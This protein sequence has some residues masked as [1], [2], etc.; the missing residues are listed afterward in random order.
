MM[1]LIRAYKAKPWPKLEIPSLNRT[2]YMYLT[3]YVIAMISAGLSFWFTMRLSAEY[4][5][6]LGLGIPLLFLLKNRY[7][8]IIGLLTF[9]VVMAFL[10]VGNS[11]YVIVTIL[12]FVGAIIAF[13]SPSFVYVMLVFWMWFEMSPYSGYLGVKNEFLIGLMLFVGWFFRAVFD[14]DRVKQKLVFHEK[15]PIIILL[16]WIVMGFGLWC[17]EPQPSGFY[18]L[19]FILIGVLFF[20]LSPLIINNDKLHTK[21]AWAWIIA[22]MFATYTA[23]FQSGGPEIDTGEMDLSGSWGGYTGAMGIQHS[24]SAS[25]LSMSLFVLVAAFYWMKGGLKKSLLLITGV[26][27]IAAIYVQESKGITFATA[28]GLGLFWLISGVRNSKHHKGIIAVFRILIM[29]MALTL[30]LIAVN[31]YG[32]QFSNYSNQISDPMGGTMAGRIYLWGVAYEMIINEGHMIR[33]IG[34]GAFWALAKDYGITWAHP[35]IPHANASESMDFQQLGVNPHNLYIDIILN[36]GLVGFALFLWLII[37]NLKRLWACYR[38]TTN[39]KYSYLSL[40]LFCALIAFYFSAIFDFTLFII[41][42]YWLYLGLAVAT[43]NLSKIM[44]TGNVTETPKAT[45]PVR[46]PLH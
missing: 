26:L 40:G 14:Q 1:E 37:G 34:V 10:F 44:V 9:E 13:E 32:A 28:L 6:S 7:L 16:V 8:T 36:Y 20:I 43:V 29:V 39:P 4:F 22:G 11:T 38:G 30:V 46:L 42:R 12:S 17:I 25:F 27:M 3:L 24:W 5:I 45:P 19:K 18:Q 23:L 33:G 41:S 15:W 2:S 31:Q 35:T 21:V